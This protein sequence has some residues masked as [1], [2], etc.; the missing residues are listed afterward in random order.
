L[1]GAAGVGSSGTDGGRVVTITVNRVAR[2]SVVRSGAYVL[3]VPYTRMNEA[4]RRAQRLG[5]EVTSVTLT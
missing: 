1:R 5:G 2:N 4:L 3:R